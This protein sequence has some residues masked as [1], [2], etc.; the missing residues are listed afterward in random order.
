MS[1]NV[2]RTRHPYPH[3]APSLL[4]LSLPVYKA[5]RFTV[6]YSKNWN[7]G[8]RVMRSNFPTRENPFC[9]PN[10][11]FNLRLSGLGALHTSARAPGPNCWIVKF[12]LPKV[13]TPHWL[14]LASEF[15]AIRAAPDHPNLRVQHT[16]PRRGS[17]T[18]SSTGPSHGRRPSSSNHL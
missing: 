1:R 15:G 9:L 7:K 10:S 13:S 18:P 14:R 3:P 17:T 12:G 11:I 5:A 16:R 6:S 4:S 2:R 8:V